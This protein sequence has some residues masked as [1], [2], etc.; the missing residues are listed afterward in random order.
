MTALARFIMRGH[1]QAALV[2]AT[3]ALLS[4][5]LP[6]FGLISAATIGLVTL[7]QGWRSGAMVGS[8]ATL[9]TAVFSLLVLGAPA[10]GLG[11]LLVLWV[12]LW[13]C[14]G[15]LRETRSLTLTFQ[16]SAASG[17]ALVLVLRL[18]VADPSAYWMQVLEPVRQTLIA[19]GLLPAEL[20]VQIVQD[21]A[22]WMTGSFAA[23]FVLQ[24]LISLIIARSWQA[25]LY[26]PGGFGAEWRAFRLGQRSGIFILLLLGGFSLTPGAGLIADLLLLVSILLVIQGLAV[27]HAL[28]Y[29]TAARRGW[30]IG[31]YLVLVLFMPQALFIVAC[32][33]L[34]DVWLDFRTRM[35]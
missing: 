9:G 26:H 32:V 1:A 14:A 7:R 35:G 24:T 34:I 31:G 3:T 12:P 25:T 8:T 33:G 21:A 22:Q 28:R 6:L 27:G 19:D 20:S 16:L 10:A 5:M 18:L 17:M 13:L 2:A 23:A 4:F 15:V 30:L 29:A 11:V